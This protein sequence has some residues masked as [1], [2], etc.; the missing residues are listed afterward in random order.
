MTLITKG[1][2]IMD[3]T[4]LTKTKHA[5]PTER[6]TQHNIKTSQIQD[7]GPLRMQAV[8]NQNTTFYPI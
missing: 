1:S 4:K 5:Y 3:P 2:V 7:Q 6:A 8:T